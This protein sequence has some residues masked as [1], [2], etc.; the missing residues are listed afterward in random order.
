MAETTTNATAE[1]TAI[2]T[3]AAITTA[4]PRATIRGG[5]VTAWA[6]AGD[7]SSPEDYP[8]RIGTRTETEKQP[9]KQVAAAQLPSEQ[10]VREASDLDVRWR[11]RTL[12]LF[13]ICNPHYRLTH[14]V[15]PKLSIQGL[16]GCYIGPE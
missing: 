5:K 2:K 1:I 15:V 12:P 7:T 6:G 13:Q 10:M 9:R 8:A 11:N 16:Y 4:D 3:V 14:Q